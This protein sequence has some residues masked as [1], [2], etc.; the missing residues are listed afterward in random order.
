MACISHS[1]LARAPQSLFALLHSPVHF[2]ARNHSVLLCTREY[3]WH[4]DVRVV[5]QL[6]VHVVAHPVHGTARAMQAENPR[7]DCLP[8]AHAPFPIGVWQAHEDH[9]TPQCE[10]VL[11]LVPPSR[12]QVGMATSS[13]SL[14]DDSALTIRQPKG[15]GLCAR[16]ALVTQE[17]VPE[18]CALRVADEA[19][20]RPDRE[21]RVPVAVHL[22]VQTCTHDEP[23][24]GPLHLVMSYHTA[25]HSHAQ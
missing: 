6:V 22:H 5:D 16:H 10:V 1:M 8:R 14:H 3:L 17:P 2:P 23:R 15:E 18:L 11:V 20:A 12:V 13:I 9:A 4:V 7:T 25:V 19:V 21:L 24:A